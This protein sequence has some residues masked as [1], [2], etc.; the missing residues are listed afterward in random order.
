M[1]ILTDPAETGAATIA[2][3]QDIQAH[4]WDFPVKFFEPTIWRI[5]RRLPIPERIQEAADLIRSSRR[6][7]IMPVVAFHYSEAWED[8]R[9]L[10]EQV[11]IPVGETFAGRGA[12][13][14]PTKWLLG[15]LG[16]TG[17]PSAG[18]IASQPTW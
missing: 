8:L 10:A 5:E 18:K 3:P 6:P 13:H 11:G 17:T 15:G 2:L 7:L 4:A 16:V 9:Q 12:I 1:R 14:T